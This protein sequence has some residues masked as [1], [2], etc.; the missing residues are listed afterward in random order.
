MEMD[1]ELTDAENKI[2]KEMKHFMALI[3]M[4]IAFGGIAMAF[5]ISSITVNGLA[6]KASD[7][8]QVLN[9]V[10]NMAIGFV[11]AGLALW[12]II[13]TAE[14]MSRFEEIQEVKDDE[15]ELPH[16]ILTTRIINLIGLYREKKPQIKRMILVSKI[17]GICFF[18]NAFIQTVILILNFNT[19]S[20]MLFSAVVGILV[21]VVMGVV[22]FFLPA[23]FNK[24]AVCWDERILKSAE[25]E[26]KIASFMEAP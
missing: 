16:E 26:K 17:A 13:S 21:S 9:S 2:K 6:L 18:A 15:K 3:I 10:S 12:F 11:V 1:F 19:G 7:S 14:V 24:Y 20:I 5:A 4:S 25:A 8:T 22:G 23:S